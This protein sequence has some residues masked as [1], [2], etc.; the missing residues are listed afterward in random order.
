M[1]ATRALT[2]AMRIA[3]TR[4]ESSVVTGTDVLEL[5]RL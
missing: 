4:P 3:L 5:L 1:P 2:S